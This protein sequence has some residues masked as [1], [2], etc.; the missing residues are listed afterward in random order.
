MTVRN[1]SSS[2]AAKPATNATAKVHLDLDTIEREGAPE[3]YTVRRGGRVYTFVD[4]MELD[5][6]ELMAALQDPPVFFKLT[7]GGDADA[8]L[9]TDPKLPVWKMR[10]LMD[11]YRRHHGMMEPGETPALPTS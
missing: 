9:A 11:D 3:P 5:W 2:T 1:N 4:A 7:L 6:Q 8:F 10:R